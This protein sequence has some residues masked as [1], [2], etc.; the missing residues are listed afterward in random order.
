MKVKLQSKKSIGFLGFLKRVLGN[1]IGAVGDVDKGNDSNDPEPEGE[2]NDKGNDLPNTIDG[3]KALLVQR[4][5]SINVLQGE[6]RGL[7][8]ESAT[9]RKAANESNKKLSEQ[10]TADLKEKEKYKELFEASEKREKELT[11]K[12]E[13]GTKKTN[14]DTKVKKFTTTIGGLKDETLLK[15]I[16]FESIKIEN[17]VVDD[18]TMNAAVAVFKEKYPY[19]LDVKGGYIKTEGAINNKDGEK[20][21]NEVGSLEH[22]EFQKMSS[23]DKIKNRHRVDWSKVK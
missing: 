3:L 19:L 17:G 22:A 10:E 9:H 12:I 16:D 14:Y 15:L 1:Q 7:I 4:D 5:A 20:T 8:S 6:K 13:A 18:T 23:V 11:E 2:S 21:P